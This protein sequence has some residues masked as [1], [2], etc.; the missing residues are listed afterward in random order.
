MI[1]PLLAVARI[2]PGPND[3]FH[4]VDAAIERFSI[5][6]P[7]AKLAALL[8]WH[9]S[10]FQF[11]HGSHPSQLECIVFVG[12]AFEVRPRVANRQHVRRLRLSNGRVS[13]GGGS[14]P[15]R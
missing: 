12:L 9:V 8:R 13:G 10:G 2:L 11:V 1:W 14:W 5:L 6:D 7:R 3:T 15:D 4:L